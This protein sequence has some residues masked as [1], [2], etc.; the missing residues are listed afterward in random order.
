MGFDDMN[1]HHPHPGLPLEGEGGKPGDVLRLSDIGFDGARALLAR[2]GLELARVADGEPIPGSYWGECEAG[3][4]GNVVLRDAG[5][6]HGVGE[7]GHRQDADASSRPSRGP[8]VLR[9]NSL[10]AHKPAGMV[11]LP[12][13]ALRAARL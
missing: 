10:R 8:R 2:Y 3:L 1:E 5:A 6:G 9:K 11:G 7:K 4:V 13:L 12:C